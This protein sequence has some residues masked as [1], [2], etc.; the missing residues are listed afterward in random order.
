MACAAAGVVA[1]AVRGEARRAGT[2]GREM[3]PHRPWAALESQSSLKAMPAVREPRQSKR[4]AGM[5]RLGTTRPFR[6]AG[7]KVLPDS[8]AEIIPLR[9]GG[10]DQW[11]MIRGVSRENPA[12]VLLHGGPG[13]SEMPLFRRFNAA[14]EQGF[15]VV[16]WDQRGAGKSFNRR[17]PR[18]SMAV[19]QFI[20]DLDELVDWVR[21]RL[22]KDRVIVLGHSWGTVLGVLYAA[23]FPEKVALYV[24]CA[25]I[26]DWHAGE[27]AS[28][29]FALEEAR[30]LDNHKALN[31]LTAIGPPPHT[32]NEL[33]KERTWIQRMA[34]QMG[35]STMVGMMRTFSAGPERS[36]FDLPAT[37]RGFRFSL[38]SMWAEVSK[39]DLAERAAE[40]EMRAV[41]FL[42]RRDHWVPPELSVAYIDALRAPSKQVVWFE[43]SGHEMFVDEPDK[44]NAAMLT[45]VRPIVEPNLAPAGEAPAPP[46]SNAA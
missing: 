36:V 44:F 5:K 10:L 26:G 12:L 35:V 46:G 1:G 29:Q 32:A 15:T 42:G 2:F 22:R 31:E 40:L 14:L 19:E 3:G 4:G 23:R 25:Q 41:F 30:R 6:D 20:S 37:Y 17:I 45:L 27:V 43:Q 21:A 11:V 7:G 18:S 13:L 33:M 16:Y 24:G 38:D 28:Y 9:L 39:L 8:I 34:G